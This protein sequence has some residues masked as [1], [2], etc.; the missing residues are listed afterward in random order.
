MNKILFV[1]IGN[2]CRSPMAEGLLRHA[3]PDRAICSAGVG[4]MR[5]YPADPLAVQIMQEQGID[6]RAHRAQSLA[7]WMVL[8]SDLIITMDLEQQAHIELLYPASKGKVGRLGEGKG[9]DVP[10]PYQLGLAS[11][12][13]AFN[14]ISQGVDRLAKQLAPAPPPTVDYGFE[15][16]WPLPAQIWTGVR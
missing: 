15:S 5:G 2:I 3:L 7:A 16:I 6:I 12:R 10:D 13:H 1:C 14:L 9:Y 11:F 8:E 4:A